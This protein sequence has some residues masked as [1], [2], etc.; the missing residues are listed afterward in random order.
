MGTFTAVAPT[1]PAMVLALGSTAPEEGA[2][3]ENNINSANAA[4]QRLGVANA[5]AA[6]NSEITYFVGNF[7]S[8]AV[9]HDGDVEG[10][11]A[12]ETGEVHTAATCPIDHHSL[13]ENRGSRLRRGRDGDPADSPPRLVFTLRDCGRRV[14]RRNPSA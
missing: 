14:S 8:L 11:P 1:C 10:A 7:G 13:L 9:R 4:G 5:Y 2:N 3:H 12:A 6:E